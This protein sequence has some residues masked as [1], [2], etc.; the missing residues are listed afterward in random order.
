MDRAGNLYIA[1]FFTQRVRKLDAQTGIITTVA[2][3]APIEILRGLS[4]MQNL[5]GFSGNGGPATR[6]LFANPQF[7]AVDGSGNLYI[8]DNANGRIRKVGPDGAITTLVGEGTR[9]PRAD[10]SLG[11]GGPATAA[12]MRSRVR[13]RRASRGTASLSRRRRSA[14]LFPPP[15]YVPCG[16]PGANSCSCKEENDLRMANRKVSKLC[17]RRWRSE[18]KEE[19]RWE[20]THRPVV[21]WRVPHWL[22]CSPEP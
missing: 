5:I 8:S 11:D 13:G 22:C 17:Q 19:M 16:S 20:P 14:H 21:A 15:R 18:T 10:G 7:V 3:S 12:I 1:D 2:G 4:P 6:A 9:Q